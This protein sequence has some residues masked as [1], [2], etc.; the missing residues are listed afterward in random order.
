MHDRV[1]GLYI[2]VICFLSLLFRVEHCAPCRVEHCAP[3]S[4]SGSF[5][6]DLR[7]LIVASSEAQ[8]AHLEKKQHLSLVNR[9]CARDHRS[10][11]NATFSSLR[12]LHARSGV[13]RKRKLRARTAW[14]CVCWWAVP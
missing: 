1:V 9:R 5:A 7:F 4:T 6:D 8:A 10:Q 3:C 13:V 11:I 2:A 14:D 12:K